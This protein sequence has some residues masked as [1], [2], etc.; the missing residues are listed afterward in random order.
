MIFFGVKSLMLLVLMTLLIGSLKNPIKF[1]SSYGSNLW[2]DTSPPLRLCPAAMYEC[3][4]S[5][6]LDFAFIL[7]L[8]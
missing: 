4:V 5:N 2:L 3:N 7:I 6:E 1:E 8:L